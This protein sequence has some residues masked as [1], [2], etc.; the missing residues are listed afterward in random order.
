MQKKLLF[1]LLIVPLA[2][3]AQK[4]EF[5]DPADVTVNGILGEA[6]TA[7]RKGRLTELP[8]WAD[9]KLIRAFSREVSDNHDKMDWYGEHAGK[10]MYT[11]ASA[12]RQSKDKALEALL[13]KTADYLV[14]EQAADGYLGDYGTNI[15]ITSTTTNHRRS[16][17]T[18]NLTYM[19]LGLLEVN[20]YFPNEKYLK[21]ANKIGELMMNTFGEGKGD[22]TKYG[23]R[24]GISATIALD[25]VVELYRATK[26]KR[27]LDFAEWIVKKGEET[28][29]VKFVAVGL[30]NGDMENIGDGKAY[31]ILW[32]LT[33]IAKLYEIN[34]KADYLKAV[35][36]AWTNVRDFHLT[37]AGGPWGGV[38][39]HLECFN[40]KGFW[41]P[42]GFVETC[43]TMSWIQLNKQLLHL[44]GDAKYAQ[45]I[46]RAAYNA[47]LGARYTNGVDWSYHSFTNGS[48][49]VAHFNDCC[50][51]SGVLALEELT[52]LVYSKKENGVAINL[53]TDSEATIKGKGKVTQK[54]MYPFDGK[55]QITVSPLTKEAFPL[56]IRV[57]DWATASTVSLNGKPV[58]SSGPYLKIEKVW[59]ASDVLEINFPMELKL[60][61]Q[62]EEALIPQGGGDIYSVNW[63]AL[64]RGPLVFAA[65]GLIDNKDR[66]RTLT[67][68]ST[69]PE[70][71]FTTTT[72]PYGQ[73]PAYILKASD[74]KNLIFVPYYEAGGAKLNNWRLTW[75]QSKIE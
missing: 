49:H 54:T 60:H 24:Y 26:D 29:G 13:L 27:Y 71:I 20:K 11:T 55:V 50:P 48:W 7:A 37:I 43:S 22:I 8:T 33:A 73:H 21:A 66:E 9:A 74:A 6:M 47:L 42:Y 18:W 28:D 58:Q 17:D 2:I 30:N 4:T 72:N 64:S 46:E 63:F 16:W 5:L 61:Q 69:S 56:F 57:P 15:R 3:N 67:L 34:G 39:K 45:E 59:K 1:L 62:K 23:T 32:N 31:Q 35:E 65:D 70:D 68:P 25:A 51:S 12:V 41:N 14:S 53:I 40:R 19:T 75:I 44:T 38:G 10:W 52:S 36:N